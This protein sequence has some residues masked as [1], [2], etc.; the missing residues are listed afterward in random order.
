MVSYK[1]V[2]CIIF[3][4][5]P[6]NLMYTIS[7]TYIG[8]HTYINQS[9][10]FFACVKTSHV[11]IYIHTNHS[12]HRYPNISFSPSLS[13]TCALSLALFLSIPVCNLG[14]RGC[15]SLVAAVAAV[16]A[17][18][19]TGATRVTGPFELL[20]A[21]FFAGVCASEMSSMYGPARR[22]V[23][24]CGDWGERGEGGRGC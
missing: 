14:E 5:W 22:K 8:I 19:D 6:G 21:A 15:V 13:R 11:Y 10:I 4:D 1:D 9:T 16:V 20:P 18:A 23:C 2:S 7:H 3:F 17:E 12:H 24:V